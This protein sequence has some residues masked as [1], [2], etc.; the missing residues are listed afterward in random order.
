MIMIA[1][2]AGRGRGE[3]KGGGKGGGGRGEHK[4]LTPSPCIV[5]GGK[6]SHGKRSNHLV[7]DS[8]PSLPSHPGPSS[9]SLSLSTQLAVTR[10]L[11]SLPAS[12]TPL[13]TPFHTPSYLQN[14]NVMPPFSTHALSP[15]QCSVCL[16]IITNVK[17]NLKRFTAHVGHT[18][19][20]FLGVS[21]TSRGRFIALVVV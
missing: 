10:S 11:S 4:C 20:A 14:A 6:V 5:R 12:P 17:L 8:L 9:P 2:A 19:F 13:S 15:C 21:G 1:Q 7:Q 16:R 18:N 3:M